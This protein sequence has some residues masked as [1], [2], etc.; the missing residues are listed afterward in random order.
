MNLIEKIKQALGMGKKEKKEEGEA[1]DEEEEDEVKE[2]L[3]SLG[4]LQ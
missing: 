2:R 1:K 4:Y 3:K